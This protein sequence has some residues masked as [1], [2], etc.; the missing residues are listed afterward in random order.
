MS[1]RTQTEALGSDF[2]SDTASLFVS[3]QCAGSL[4][5]LGHCTK[6]SMHAALALFPSPKSSLFIPLGGCCPGLGLVP[7]ERE[8]VSPQKVALGSVSRPASNPAALHLFSDPDLDRNQ[9]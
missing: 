2:K 4:G 1:G 7:S 3:P 8:Q 5:E 9:S 6:V